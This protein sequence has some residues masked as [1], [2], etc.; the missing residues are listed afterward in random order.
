MAIRRQLRHAPGLIGYALMAEVAGKTFWTFSVWE[1]R[2]SLDEFARSSPH[3]QIIR[4]LRPRMGQTVF[5]FATADGS[6]LP[7]GWEEV[8]RQLQQDGGDSAFGPVNSPGST[9]VT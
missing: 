9:D 3:Y 5:T 7:W 8:K 2:G 4:K 1:N 6:R